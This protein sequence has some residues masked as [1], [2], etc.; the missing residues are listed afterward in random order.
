MTFANYFTDICWYFYQLQPIFT[1]NV[2]WLTVKIINIYLF[3]PLHCKNIFLAILPIFSKKTV[4]LGSSDSVIKF[5]LV[6][7][8]ID[9]LAISFVLRVYPKYFCDYSPNAH[10]YK[11]FFF[12]FTLLSSKLES[13]PLSH[14]S[15][16]G[17]VCQQTWAIFTTL[18]FHCNL[19]MGPIS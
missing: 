15:C 5:R 6:L 4:K 1:K 11:D 13:L 18:H 7:S 3:L 12:Q 19:Q 17:Y 14:T 8:Y 16:V 2:L 9:T 10:C